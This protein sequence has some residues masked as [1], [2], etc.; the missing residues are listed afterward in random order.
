M[1]KTSTETEARLAQLTARVDQALAVADRA[2]RTN[3]AN[4]ALVD[5]CLDVRN[6]LAPDQPGGPR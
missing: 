2:M 1:R 4:R 5:V 6:T 3:L